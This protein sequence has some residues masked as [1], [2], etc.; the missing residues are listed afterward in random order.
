VPG[1]LQRVVATVYQRDQTAAPQCASLFGYRAVFAWGALPSLPLFF[2][3]DQAYFAAIAAAHPS[4]R[5]VVASNI[6]LALGHNP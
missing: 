5:M 1:V 2:S 4:S 3:V 6:S